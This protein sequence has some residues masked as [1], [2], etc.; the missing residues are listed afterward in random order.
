VIP[1]IATVVDAHPWEEAL[2]H[3]A[4]AAGL[5]RIRRRCLGPAD[6]EGV[7]DE[8]DAVVLG[9]DTPW[10]SAP[11]IAGWSARTAVVGIVGGS[12]DPMCRV[13][14]AGGCTAVLPRSAPPTVVLAEI[15]CAERITPPGP[16]RG[17]VLAVTGARGAP[18]VTEIAL[19][20]SWLAAGSRRTLLVEADGEAPSLGLRLG[21]PPRPA[22]RPARVGALDVLTTPP[23]GSG[24]AAVLAAQLVAASRDAYELTV[25][26]RGAGPPAGG[27]DATILVADPSP[28]GLVRTALL[29]ARWEAAA[30]LLVGNRLDPD[31]DG[32]LRRLRSA[33]GLEPAAVVP[34]AGRIRAGDIPPRRLLAAVEPLLAAVS[35][36][37]AVATEDP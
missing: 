14:A 16:P 9:G 19:A 21:I 32:A 35:E 11:L 28:V 2:V 27:V 25:V 23:D 36:G 8:V 31:D 30:P 33:T 18:G 6:V 7:V 13:L 37:G 10:V 17:S 3:T 1:T 26:D 24:L 29:L 5:A 20:L 22:G 12:S 34:D 4:R 15:A